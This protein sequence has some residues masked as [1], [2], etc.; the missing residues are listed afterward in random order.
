MF[1]VISLA[2]KR[3]IVRDYCDRGPIFCSS[4]YCSSELSNYASDLGTVKVIAAVKRCLIRPSMYLSALVSFLLCGMPRSLARPALLL[5][6]S[7][8]CLSPSLFLAGGFL[9]H[10]PQDPDIGL[11]GR[12]PRAHRCISLAGSSG[13]YGLTLVRYQVTKSMKD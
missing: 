9:L 5:S 10:R 7:D 1:N 11:D 8:L 6:L 3:Q 4:L 13:Q 12:P 2:L